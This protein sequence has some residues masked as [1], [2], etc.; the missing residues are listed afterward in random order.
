MKIFQVTRNQVELEA[1]LYRILRGSMAF[2]AESNLN[3]RWDREVADSLQPGL[4][5]RTY[6]RHYSIAPVAQFKV[7]S[8]PV[9]LFRFF[10]KIRYLRGFVA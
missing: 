7:F 5:Q 3:L 10:E 4:V 2:T 8:E 9:Y 1:E 6:F